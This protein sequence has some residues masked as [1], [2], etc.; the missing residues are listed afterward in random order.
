MYEL[1]DISIRLL[2]AALLGAAIGLEREL[3]QKA[4]GLRTHALIAVGS[5]LF[6]LLSHELVGASGDPG[7]VAAQIV[8]GIGFLG[9]G[10][11]LRTG[12]SVRGLTTAATIWVNAAIGMAAGAGRWTVA[13]GATVATLLILTALVPVERFVERRAERE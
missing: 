7:R 5:A 11:I 8:S 4:A 13:V 2:V 10:T 9:G 6:T 1:Y 12:A 3:R